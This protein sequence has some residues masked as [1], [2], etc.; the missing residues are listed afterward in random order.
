MNF[1]NKL[2]ILRILL[3]PLLILCFYIPVSFRMWIA[4]VVF[5]LAAVTDA[6]DG[7]YARKHNLCSDFGRFLDPIADKLLVCS[8]LIMLIEYKSL[9]A[10]IAFV[11]IGREFIISGFRLIAANHGQVISA[12]I[13]GKI[14]TVF[15]CIMIPFWMMKDEAV[16]NFAPVV[17]TI[18]LI[19]MWTVT[20]ISV[21][22][23]VYSCIDYLYKNRKVISLK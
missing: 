19:C 1:A 7:R 11:L 4:T 10:V 5:I 6:L 3:V 23:S 22:A 8:A 21:I 9:P 18:F 16:F 2:T 17:T 14:K 12:G 20:A 15:Q 13:M